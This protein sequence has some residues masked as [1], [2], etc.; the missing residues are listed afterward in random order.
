MQTSYTTSNGCELET[1]GQAT[2]PIKHQEWNTISRMFKDLKVDLPVLATSG[3]TASNGG[4]E[5]ME[6]CKALVQNVE[7]CARG[8]FLAHT[9]MA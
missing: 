5:Y 6:E 7:V 2:L 9:E 1:N 4:V 8:R 3:M